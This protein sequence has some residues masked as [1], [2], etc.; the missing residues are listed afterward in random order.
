MAAAMANGAWPRSLADISPFAHASMIGSASTCG[1]ARKC[2]I[3][4]A[5]TAI[6]TAIA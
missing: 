5:T 2:P 4:S 3:E 1:R 6:A